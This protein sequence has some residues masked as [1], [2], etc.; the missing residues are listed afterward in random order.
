MAVTGALD[1]LDDDELAR[2]A[3]GL[4]RVLRSRSA[5]EPVIDL[6]SNDYLSLARDP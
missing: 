6:A 4:R 5:V 1:W 2:R 3:A